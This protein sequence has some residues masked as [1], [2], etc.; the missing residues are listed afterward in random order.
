[1]TQEQYSTALAGLSAKPKRHIHIDG[2]QPRTIEEL[3]RLA[4]E[5]GFIPA[6][7]PEAEVGPGIEDQEPAKPAEQVETL[8]KESKPQ[9]P[10]APK[11]SKAPKTPR[12]QKANGAPD[13][14]AAPAKPAEAATGVEIPE[15]LGIIPYNDLRSLAS[16]LGVSPVP[17]AQSELLAAIEAKRPGGG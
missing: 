7:Q 16:R 10:K 8:A 9:E 15:N 17:N 2:R 12:T 1:M 11:E 14:V 4:R 13:K 3:N 5:R 6:S